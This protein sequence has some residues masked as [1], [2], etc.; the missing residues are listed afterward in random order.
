VNQRSSSVKGEMGP[1]PLGRLLPPKY[2]SLPQRVAGLSREISFVLKKNGG[3]Y[4]RKLDS[5]ILF[6]VWL[7]FFPFPFDAGI[8]PAAVDP[9]IL[10]GIAADDL[11]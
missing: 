7:R 8:F 11:L 3:E 2:T 10:F 9:P 5:P 1:S 4:H 6:L